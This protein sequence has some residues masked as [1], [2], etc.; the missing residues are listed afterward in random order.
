MP[1]DSV[2]VNWIFM[3]LLQIIL[4]PLKHKIFG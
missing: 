2:S 1:T 3:K 4:G